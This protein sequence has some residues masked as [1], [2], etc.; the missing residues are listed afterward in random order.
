[1]FPEGSRRLVG[2][3]QRGRTASDFPSADTVVMLLDG[4]IVASGY[5]RETLNA[6]NIKK[7]YG[8]DVDILEGNG[9][10]VILTRLRKRS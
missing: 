7:I 10:P 5:V 1:M 6:G 8:V 9:R 4:R 2:M 3:E